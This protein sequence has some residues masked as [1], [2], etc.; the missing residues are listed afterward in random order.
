MEKSLR[1]WDENLHLKNADM[2]R[3]NNDLNNLVLNMRFLSSRDRGFTARFANL[4]DLK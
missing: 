2:P 4:L 3:Y 1:K